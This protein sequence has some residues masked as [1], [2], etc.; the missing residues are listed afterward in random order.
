MEGREGALSRHG[1]GFMRVSR[2]ERLCVRIELSFPISIS[3]RL[4]GHGPE[5]GKDYV[6]EF[7][8]G[9]GA[10]DNNLLSRNQQKILLKW[11]FFKDFF[12]SLNY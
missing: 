6:F 8:G 3:G 10:I 7:R 11:N 12:N 5:F 4:S 2:P 9:V 1:H